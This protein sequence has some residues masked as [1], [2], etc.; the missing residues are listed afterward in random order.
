MIQCNRQRMKPTFPYRGSIWIAGKDGNAYTNLDGKTTLAL[1]R[2]LAPTKTDIQTL[3]LELRNNLQLPET[4]LAAILGV[5][6]ITLRKWLSGKRSPCSA[7]KKLIW[8]T[9]RLLTRNAGKPKDFF[10]LAVWLRSS[11][12]TTESI[13]PRHKPANSDFESA[14]QSDSLEIHN[15]PSAAFN[16]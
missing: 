15:I 10:E 6:L 7:A 9:H 1:A 13:L 12:Q 5:P 8:L 4:T 3:L 14:S 11:E 16:S 2:L